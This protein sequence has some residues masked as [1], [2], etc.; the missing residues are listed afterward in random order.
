MIMNQSGKRIFLGSDK[1]GYDL[2]K[3]IEAYLATKG[4]KVL[5]LGVFKDD[6]LDYV[7]IENEVGEKVYEHKDSLG[8]LVIGD[9]Y[10]RQ[11]INK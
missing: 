6:D 9:R 8:V 2:K 1:K 5:D 3:D 4:H 10:P 11:N 7:D